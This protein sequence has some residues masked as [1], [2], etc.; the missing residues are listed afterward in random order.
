MI[1]KV[2]TS[3]EV[4]I[5]ANSKYNIDVVKWGDPTARPCLLL[6]YNEQYDGTFVN[7]TCKRQQAK[8]RK[9]RKL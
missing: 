7:V 2:S 5:T 4:V 8:M 1:L 3:S 9:Q 6:V